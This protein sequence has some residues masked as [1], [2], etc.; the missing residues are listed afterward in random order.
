MFLKYK[1]VYK[2]EIII[3]IIFIIGD[4]QNIGKQIF[5]VFP[6]GPTKNPEKW[7]ILIERIILKCVAHRNFPNLRFYLIIN[8]HYFV[9]CLTFA[10]V[11]VFHSPIEFPFVFV[12]FSFGKAPPSML[13]FHL[14][15]L[16]ILWFLL[17]NPIANIV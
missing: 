4:S 5:P 15:A 2:V 12:P 10:K 16:L 9:Y 6:F 7:Y 14:I 1:Y 8:V 11:F 13:V 3:N 17:P